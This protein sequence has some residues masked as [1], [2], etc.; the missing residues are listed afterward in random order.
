[1]CY[2]LDAEVL[3]VNLLSMS[4]KPISIKLLKEVRQKIEAEIPSL[5]IDISIDSLCFA[6]EKRPEM[7]KWCG[8]EREEICRSNQAKNLFSNKSLNRNFNWQIP[9]NIKTS[10]LT[11]L[12]SSYPI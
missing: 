1:M 7:F 12:N 10:F 6:V 8:A 9:Q 3:L 5:I 4:D 2:N 11:L